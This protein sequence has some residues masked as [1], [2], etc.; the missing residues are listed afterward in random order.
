MFELEM[1]GYANIEIIKIGKFY[2]K[3]QFLKIKLWL[4]SRVTHHFEM[5]S[6]ST[7]VFKY[8]LFIF[9]FTAIPQHVCPCTLYIWVCIKNVK[10]T[11]LCCSEHIGSQKKA[12]MET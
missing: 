7:V 11:S 6:E 8:I 9:L 1:L 10:H 3:L 4:F 5:I 12:E 2:T